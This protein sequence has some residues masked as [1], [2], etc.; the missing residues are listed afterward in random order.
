MPPLIGN[1]NPFGDP[2]WYQGFHSPHYT[3]S[4]RALG[5]M[6]REVVETDLIPNVHEWDEAG[7][8]PAEFRH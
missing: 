7:V 6:V 5:R 3:D 2:S 1:M 4:H 8:I